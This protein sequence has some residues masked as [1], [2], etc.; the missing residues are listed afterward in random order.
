MT[1]FGDDVPILVDDDRS[2]ESDKIAAVAE[3]YGCS[4]MV[5]KERRGHF[6]GDIQ[7]FVNAIVFGKEQQSDL[8]LKISQRVVPVL[9][10][11]RE[12]F[13]RAFADP[14]IMVA[15]PG[16]PRHIA[17]PM[18]RFYSKFG[19]LTDVVGIRTGA[20]EASDLVTVYRER[21][22]NSKNLADALVETTWGHLIAT[23]F[24]SGAAVLPELA[25]PEPFKAKIYLRK[26]QAMEREYEQV[27]A[28]HGIKGQWNVAEWAVI[29]G[30]RYFC[31]PAKI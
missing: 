31:R 9:P 3:K 24:P 19:I 25:N 17:R 30:S 10:A 22:Q 2:P 12:V 23:K 26:S 21:F 1:I 18:A 27:A 13:E 29:E 7:T 28:M 8:T 20:M 14:K 6:A 11:F 5:G 16:R 4:Y 15:L